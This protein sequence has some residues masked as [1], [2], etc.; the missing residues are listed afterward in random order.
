MFR[1]AVDKLSKVMDEV[2]DIDMQVDDA[3][4]LVLHQA[5]I[6]IIEGAAEEDGPCDDQVVKTVHN[7]ANTSAASIPASLPSMICESRLDR[8]WHSRQSKGF[9]Q[10]CACAL[11]PPDR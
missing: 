3:D 1:H 8:C 6:R 5:N 7:H 9:I 11:W 2:L 4:W 10:R